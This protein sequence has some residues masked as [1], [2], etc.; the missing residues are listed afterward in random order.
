MEYQAPYNA[1][2]ILA[3]WWEK[4]LSSVQNPVSSIYTGLLIGF[5]IMDFDQFH[6]I[7]Y[8]N[9]IYRMVP[10]PLYVGL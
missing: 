2:M 10:P 6:Y 7:G 5:P 3:F 4:N 9:L 8:Y 1:L